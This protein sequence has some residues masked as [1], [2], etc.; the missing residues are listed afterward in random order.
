MGSE[1]SGLDDRHAYLKLGNDVARFAF[2]YLDLPTSTPGFVPR[3]SADGEMSFNP[4][5]L[6]P[7]Q[8]QQ[9]VTNDG[10]PDSDAQAESASED[11]RIYTND[12]ET[13]GERL[14]A[15]IT[16]TAALALPERGMSTRHRVHNEGAW[17]R[18]SLHAET[19]RD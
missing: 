3:K 17:Q 4:A 16:K 15:D 13:F 19:S 18:R 1:I 9:T 8:P 14:A 6:E 2:D 5:T 10:V 11:A 7:L 12:S